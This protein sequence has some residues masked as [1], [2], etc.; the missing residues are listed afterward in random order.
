M[1][2]SKNIVDRNSFNDK[3]DGVNGM[4]VI[5]GDDQLISRC[6]NKNYPM[7]QTVTTIMST[8]I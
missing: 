8:G 7:K 1:F 6:Q 2:V 3:L 5:S 4:C